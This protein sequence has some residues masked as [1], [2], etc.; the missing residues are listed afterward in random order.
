MSTSI[1]G[2]EFLG[3]SSINPMSTQGVQQTTKLANDPG[4]EH[5]PDASS[6]H[7]TPA[8]ASESHIDAASTVALTSPSNYIEQSTF[9]AEFAIESEHEMA[10]LV[11]HFSEV[12]GPWYEYLDVNHFPMITELLAGSTYMTPLGTFRDLCH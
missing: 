9:F 8:L 3:S 1:P 5:F 4:S 7:S 2:A 11:R 12:I 10:F 6:A